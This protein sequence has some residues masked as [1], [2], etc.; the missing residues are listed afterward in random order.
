MVR[1][2]G[3][4]VEVESLEEFDALVAAGARAMHGWRLQSV[5]LSRRGDVLRRLDPRGAVFLGC[6]M[7]PDAEKSVRDRGGLLFPEIP[8][9]P[10]NPYRATLYSPDELYDGLADGPYDRTPDARCYAWSRSWRHDVARTLAAALHDHAVDDALSDAIDAHSAVGVMGGHRTLRDGTAYR[11]AAVLGRAL[12]RAGLLVVTGGGPGAMEAANLGGY[13]AAAPDAVL[14]ACLH[15]LSA[16]ADF[17]TSVTRW[18]RT[19]LLVRERVKATAQPTETY[20]IPTWFY[21]HEPPNVFASSIAKYFQNSVREDTL[22]RHCTAGIVFLP[23]AAGTVQEVFQDACENY[24]SD[25]AT[26]AP[27]V[28]VGTEHWTTRVPAWPLL[29]TLAAGSPL[30]GRVHLVDSV[31]EVVSVLRG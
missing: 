4:S 16:V 12:A 13:L 22:L 25:T 15:D 7:S 2:S 21:G 26:A 17:R 11:K 29:S 24:Y 5:D 14:E 9:V 8:D 19:A 18:A 6:S 28:L 27:M 30:E 23:G 10:F 31:E 1:R 20:G 3:R